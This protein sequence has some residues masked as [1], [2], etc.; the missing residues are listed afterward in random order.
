MRHAVRGY[1]PAFSL[2]GLLLAGPSAV[3]GAENT[4][5]DQFEDKCV[6][7][8]AERAMRMLKSD[9]ALWLK[10][11]EAAY[12]GK[13]VAAIT[14]EEYLTWFD[15]LAGKDGTWKKTDA[16]NPQIGE[17]FDKVVQRLELGPVP[18]I[19]REEYRKYARRVLREGNPPREEHDPNEDADKAFRVLDR[20]GNGEIDDNEFT[21]GLKDEKLRADADGNGRISKDEYRDYFRRRTTVK[22]DMLIAAKSGENGR[23]SDGKNGKPGTGKAANALPDWFT[24]LDLDKDGQISLFEWR[25]ANKPTTLFQEMDL[26]SDGL[27]TKDEY[28]RYVRLKEIELNQKKR[29]EENP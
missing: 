10:E 1:L 3:R 23:N 18:S 2:A 25:K 21:A 15:L 5:L 6:T 12:P 24:A 14:D 4:E 28:L 22:T 11:L 20:N 19:S 9:R 16:S 7:R 26:N 29:E 17:L 13:V 27:L 8:A